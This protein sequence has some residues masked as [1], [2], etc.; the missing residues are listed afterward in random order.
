M[1]GSR[2]VSYILYLTDPALEWQREWGGNLRLFSTMW[3]K[4]A[5]DGSVDMP[6]I[7]PHNT[8]RI[9]WNKLA[10]FAVQPGKSFHDVEEVYAA[11]TDEKDLGRVRVAISG[12]YHV[13]QEGE[14]GYR[15]GEAEEHEAKSGRLALSKADEF[16]EPYAVPTLYPEYKAQKD[17]EVVVRLTNHP[18][19]ESILQKRKAAFTPNQS[20]EDS[21]PIDLTSDDLD[22]LLKYVNPRWLVPDTVQELLDEFAEQ[23]SLRI[24]DFLSQRFADALKANLDTCDATLGSSAQVMKQADW[25]VA[26]PSH[27]QKYL[28]RMSSTDG[29]RSIQSDH[30]SSELH[31]E[32]TVQELMCKLFPSQAFR[33]WLSLVTSTILRSYDIRARR[34]RRGVDY[35]LAMPY[36]EEEPRVEMVLCITPGGKWE[37]SDGEEDEHHMDVDSEGEAEDGESTDNR[38]KIGS[39]DVPKNSKKMKITKM[40][41]E[42]PRKDGG[43]GR[44][45]KNS[46]DEKH[47]KALFSHLVEQDMQET[48]YGGYEVWMA[49]E[50]EDDGDDTSD[51]ASNDAGPSS[52]KPAGTSKK[53]YLDPA[54]YQTAH[55]ASGDSGVLFSMPAGWNRLSLVLRDKGTLRFVKYVSKSSGCDRWDVAGEWA[56]D[57]KKTDALEDGKEAKESDEHGGNGMDVDDVDE[58]SQDLEAETGDQV[59]EEVQPKPVEVPPTNL[60]PSK[61]QK[62][63]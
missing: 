14:E 26:Q 24:D 47:S 18:V 19:N 2:K 30:L 56:V 11:G 3:R 10:L 54:I 49:G 28:Y 38:D 39:E 45:S 32:N 1:I 62:H 35:Q 15:V 33:K 44:A 37:D 5:T 8:L 25:K 41:G 22:F 21:G 51:Q 63:R 13:P 27:K 34:F 50:E 52:S 4:S 23:S 53:P 29:M 55:D 46:K 40:N 58:S 57:W 31:Q 61:K 48:N 17:A 20:T 12:W 6:S 36:K 16:D 60:R 59:G 42:E 7:D 43:K 9:G